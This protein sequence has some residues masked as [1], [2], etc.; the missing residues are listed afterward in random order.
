MVSQIII[1]RFRV[2]EIDHK[3]ITVKKKNLRHMN[4]NIT[5]GNIFF[6]QF[7]WSSTLRIR[8]QG[9]SLVKTLQ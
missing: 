7:L 1:V 6:F 2:T 5:P 3:Y 8:Q 9:T 4:E